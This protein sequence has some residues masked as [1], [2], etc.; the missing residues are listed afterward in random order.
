MSD[1][2]RRRFL[3]G[4]GA[5]RQYPGRRRDPAQNCGFA[6]PLPYRRQALRRDRRPADTHP[7]QK[8]ASHAH[9]KRV[10]KPVVSKNTNELKTGA[11]GRFGLEVPRLGSPMEARILGHEE[12]EPALDMVVNRPGFPGDSIL[13][14]VGVSGKPGAVQ[15]A[16]PSIY[17]SARKVG[18]Q[19]AA[20]TARTALGPGSLPKGRLLI[21]ETGWLETA[22]SATQ[23]GQLW[24]C[25]DR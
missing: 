19:R 6:C 7:H 22:P 13:S 16:V 8:V 10:V 17:S 20:E 25:R 9:A 24:H 2:W 14:R 5:Q 11:P 23:S 12:A 1:S 3:C 15:V 4:C 18:L 21:A